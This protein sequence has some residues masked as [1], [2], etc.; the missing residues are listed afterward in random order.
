MSIRPIKGLSFS[1]SVGYSDAKIKK[2]LPENET[3]Y[4]NNTI[5]QI[6]GFTAELG[7]DI[8]MPLSESYSL[9]AHGDITHRGEVYWD[10]QNGLKTSPKTFFNAKVGIRKGD[11]TLSFV[12]RNLSNE[13]TPAAVGAHAFG[14]TSLLSYNEP[15]QYGVELGVNF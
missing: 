4:H 12:G 8:D 15:R 6:Y 7:T 2:F 9:V 13:R 3:E 10:V 14:T 5:P 1:G 11:W